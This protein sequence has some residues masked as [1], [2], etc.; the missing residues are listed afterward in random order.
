MKNQVLKG[1]FARLAPILLLSAIPFHTALAQTATAPPLGTAQSFAVLGASKVTNTGNT[2]VN[3]DLGV[4]AGTAITGIPP[5]IVNGTQHSADVVAQQAQADTTNAFNNMTGQPCEFTISTD[6][7]G[8]TLPSGVY[9]FAAASAGLTGTLTLDGQNN[10]ASVWI[11]KMASTL[12]TAS[13]SKIVLINGAQNCNV[14]WQVGSSATIGTNTTFVGNILAS[15]SIT[16][17]TGATISGRALAST[18]AVTMDTNIVSVCTVPATGNPTVGKSFTPATITAGG[19]STITI[20]LSNAN[21][22]PASIIAPLTDT[23]PSGVLV[24]A[25]PN[26]STTCVSSTISTTPSSVTLTGGSI[27]ANGACTMTVDVTAPSGGSYTNTLPIGA[28]QTNNG[29]NLNLV[30]TTLTVNPPVTVIP[31]TLGKSFTPDT[32]TAGGV[33]T[34]TITLSN[35]DATVASLTAPLVDTLPTGVVIAPTPNVASTCGGTPSATS[36]G[37]T[38]SLTGGSIPSGNSCTLTVEVTAAGAGTFQNSLAAGALKTSNGN[39]GAPAVATLTVNTIAGTPVPPTLGKSFSPATINAG[40]VSTL[41][42]TLSNPG[43]LPDTLTSSLVDTLPPGVVIAA[44]P[45]FSTTCSGAGTAIAGG[46]S[47][48]LG[49][50]SVIPLGSCTVTVGVTAPNGGSYINSLGAGALN[51]NNG[52]NAAPVAATLTVSFPSPITLGKSFTPATINEGS[53]S[54]L[55][56]TFSN[57]GATPATLTAPLTDLL[58]SG[59]VMASPLAFTSTCGG[60]VAAAAGGSSVTLGTGAVIPANSSCTIAVTVTAPVAGSYINSLLAASLQT[61]KGNN[62]APA[63]ATLTVTTPVVIPPSLKKSFS[64]ST[65]NAGG[66]STLTITL[67]NFDSTIANLTAPLIDTL[68]PGVVIASPLTFSTDCGGTLAATSGGSTIT[69]TGGSIEAVY[70]TTNGSCTITVNVTAANAGSYVNTLP[71]GALQTTNG[72][73]ATKAKAELDVTP[74]AA[75]TLRKSFS[76]SNVNNGGVS[77]VTITLSN[78]NNIPDTLTAPLV[79]TFPSGLVI[80]PTPNA[81]TTCVGGIVTTGVSLV[82][83]TGGVIPARGSCTV[84]VNVTAAGI[85][86]YVN[87]LP[88]SALQTNN[89]SNTAAASATLSVTLIVPPS[90]TKSF[91][92]ASVDT[93]LVSTVRI[94]LINSNA[95]ISTLTGP[96]VDTLPSGLVTSGSASTT[97]GGTATAGG[98]TVTLTGGSIPANGS[99]RV[100]VN[101]TAANPGSYV[102]TLPVGA[103]QTNNGNNTVQAVATLIVNTAPTVSKS[104]NPSTITA[105]GVSTLTITLTNPNNAIATITDELTDTLP[106]GEFIATLPNASTTCVG[107][108]VTATGG[109]SNVTLSGGV[110]PANG[111]CTIKVNV[112]VNSVYIN[113]LPAGVLQ[114]DKGNSKTPAVATL[115]VN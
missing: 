3:G 113:T 31:P 14:F 67:T 94:T 40:G 2:V 102:N 108:K 90:L 6:L 29:N 69:L 111:F 41:T 75:P 20:T 62:A 4:Y 72:N 74:L 42:I 24:A 89:G 27:P 109:G 39:N 23:L 88:V 53:S 12:T 49:T 79:D 83:L 13:S 16:L 25:T 11:F 98:S 85:G 65:I 78:T 93:G 38:V 55:T 30:V 5:G 26:A 95:T 60:T 9:C 101:V 115:I 87:L 63:I 81:N 36:G 33:S 44:S 96:L 46:S 82:T 54:T 107:G 59:V 105:G 86:S 114:T 92:P 71:V 21:S 37:S 58:P 1:L 15:A 80:A 32:I 103:L 51:T 110:I 8:L 50:G 64:P 7:G 100:T 66:T 70:D 18:A 28:L 112:T 61:N 17:T 48:T 77:T 10:P 99:C 84:T 34:L 35:S 91:N 47:V 76:P 45:A 56:I 43:T 97:C 19:T 73:N 57:I 68:P 52:S 106:I 22:A 104:F